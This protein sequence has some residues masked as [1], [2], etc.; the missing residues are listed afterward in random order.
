SQNLDSLGGKILRV[1]PLSGQGVPGNPFYSASAGE[2]KKRVWA[3]G[4]RNPFRFSVQPGTGMLY[5]AD[6]GN[7]KY[8]EINLGQ[9]GANY[10]W[11]QTEGPQPPNLAGVNYP[12]F[13]FM[14]DQTDGLF[15][16]CQS[17]IGGTF[18][19]GS[20]F[21][22]D[23]VGDYL[24]AD[25]VCKRIWRLEPGSST[26]SLFADLSDVK[27][28]GIVH[29]GFGPDGKLYMSDYTN[30]RLRRIRYTTSNRPPTA[31]SSA[32]TDAGPLP[33]TVN[34]SSGG[35][36]DPDGDPISYSW[37]FGDG[38]TSSSANPQH[39]YNIPGNF[40]VVLTVT[41]SK[42]AS[43]SAAPITISAGNNKPQVRITSPADGTRV[44]AERSLTVEAS[45]ADAE[46]GTLTPDRLGWNIIRHHG[47][48]HTHPWAE[49][50]GY[51]MTTTMPSPEDLATAGTSFL[52][53]MVTATDSSGATG[54]ASIMLYPET[55][56]LQFETRP[57]GL[58]LLLDGV[59]Y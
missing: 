27:Y 48:S 38:S 31:Q 6:V 32:N 44:R 40:Q 34:F 26:V 47:T 58:R 21:P 29:L 7:S 24:F 43:T 13:S 14:H 54:K 56:S 9:A 37:S 41:D 51:S 8:E 59:S 11:P 5:I 57:A 28:L 23:Y 52:E 35:S 36:S 18:I 55:A 53:I 10:G 42:G 3:Y 25:Y 45:A 15:N 30:S 39:T 33:L 19:T 22:A 12:F 1:D 46:D 20:N 49:G 2:N 50:R 16:G 4:L 17:I